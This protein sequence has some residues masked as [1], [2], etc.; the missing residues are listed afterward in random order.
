MS[1]K[2][3]IGVLCVAALLAAVI[4]TRPV[5]SSAVAQQAAAQ[6][7]TR[8]TVSPPESEAKTLFNQRCAEC[9]GSDGRAYMAPGEVGVARTFTDRRW[10][11][12][13]SDK[14]LIN[15]I[16]RGRGGMPSFKGTLSR[17]QIKVLVAYVR[18]FGQDTPEGDARTVHD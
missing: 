3:A 7:G 18:R 12:E 6:K 11:A 4:C 10:Q 17:K 9:H 5:V 16:T 13:V 15:S 8:G 1:R 14:R 2:I